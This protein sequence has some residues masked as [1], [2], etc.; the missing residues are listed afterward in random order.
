MHRDTKDNIYTKS[1]FEDGLSNYSHYNLHQHNL[2][3]NALLDLILK[4]KKEGKLLEIGCA[5]GYFLRVAENF[6]ETYGVDISQHAIEYAKNVTNNT[7]LIVGDAEMILD[8]IVEKNKHKFDVVVALDVLEH[9]SNPSATIEI[10]HKLLSNE[11]YFVFKV[12]NTSCIDLKIYSLMGK[13]ELW[14]GYKDKGHISLLKLREW[15]QILENV[16][17]EYRLIPHVPTR[18]LKNHIAKKFP[19]KYFIPTIF[20]LTNQSVTFLCKKNEIQL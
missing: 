3:W 13:K 7:D 10:I 18:Y 17:F 4:Y 20:Y 5:Y 11:G 16:G 14:H 6:F 19:D 12:P 8:T 15:K 1:Y 9:L 2:Y